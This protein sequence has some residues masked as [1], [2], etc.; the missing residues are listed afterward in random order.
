MYVTSALRVM[1]Y[2]L[3]CIHY[4]HRNSHMSLLS[5]VAGNKAARASNHNQTQQMK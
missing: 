1:E 5:Q 2:L 4:F 3:F